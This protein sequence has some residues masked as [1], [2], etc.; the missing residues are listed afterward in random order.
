MVREVRERETRIPARGVSRLR[1]EDWALE[2]GFEEG[3]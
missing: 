3:E 2:V 1:E